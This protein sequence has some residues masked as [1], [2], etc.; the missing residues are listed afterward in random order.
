MFIAMNRFKVIKGSEAAFEN[1]WLSRDSHLDKVPGFVEFHLLRVPKLR[2]THYMPLTR[3]GKTERCLKR[4][5]NPRH[6]E[7]RIVG[8]G[9][10]S[11]CIWI[12]RSS[13]GS[14]C[15]RRWRAARRRCDI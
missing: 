14:R 15:A 3:S 6:S 10:T 2:I 9:T 7:P 5:P 13:R 11:R 12:I 1:V 8:Q 4:G